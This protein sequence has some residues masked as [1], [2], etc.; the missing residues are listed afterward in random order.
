[1]A[2]L[3]RVLEYYE[4]IILLTTNRIMSLDVA[5]E[6]RIHLAIQYRDLTSE[7]VQK[8]FHNFLEDIDDNLI[9][10]RKSINREVRSLVKRVR[11]NGRQIRNIVMSAL[12]LAGS[13]NSKLKVRHIE[14]AMDAT[15]AFLDSLMNSTREKRSFNE[16]PTE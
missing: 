14:R 5:V 9:A 12:L 10:D 6:S 11:L 2:V 7:Q 13:E 15:N 3:L 4:G 16:A 1:V 8:I